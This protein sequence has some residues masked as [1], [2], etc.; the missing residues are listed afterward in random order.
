MASPEPCTMFVCLQA[1]GLAVGYI[2]GVLPEPT[3]IRAAPW[4]APLEVARV[5]YGHH[6]QIAATSV[7]LL[8]AN[9]AAMP[10]ARNA[11]PSI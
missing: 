10:G 8:T 11:G 4:A 1:A 2:S 9:V 3:D 6:T 7:A 5:S